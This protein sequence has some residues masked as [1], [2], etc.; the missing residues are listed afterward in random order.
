MK[1]PDYP[2]EIAKAGVKEDKAKLA[3]VEAEMAAAQGTTT[4]SWSVDDY[5]TALRDGLGNI[6][7]LLDIATGEERNKLYQL[8]GL[9]L[10]YTRTGPG[11]GHLVGALRPRIEPRRAMLRVGGGTSTLTP[12]LEVTGQR[13]IPAA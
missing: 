13:I 12:R 1:D 10:T 9:E 3:R 6:A 8:L 5:R 4:R 2:I 7:G 11:S